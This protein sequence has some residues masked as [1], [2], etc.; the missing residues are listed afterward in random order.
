M[1]KQE[2]KENEQKEEEGESVDEYMDGLDEIPTESVITQ[3]GEERGANEAID[4]VEAWMPDTD[5]MKDETNID[6]SQVKGLAAARTL[7][8]FFPE[9]TPIQ[10]AI[11]DQLDDY[12]KYA[13]SQD[14]KGREEQVDVLRGVFG[15]GRS[16]DQH[17]DGGANVFVNSE[18][19]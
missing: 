6:A 16:N 9:L 2:P 14:G 4:A 19:D 8:K 18:E 1:S 17:G 15:R 12:E 5:E 13:I 10:D 7:P 11:D 3:Y